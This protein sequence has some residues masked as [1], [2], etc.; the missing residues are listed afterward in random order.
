MQMNHS[1]NS[2]YDAINITFKKKHEIDETNLIILK[3]TYQSSV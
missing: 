1:M 3:D 2:L